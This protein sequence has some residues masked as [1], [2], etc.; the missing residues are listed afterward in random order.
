M[1]HVTFRC[2]TCEIRNDQEVVTQLTQKN[3]SF[4][5]ECDILESASLSQEVGCGANPISPSVWPA[6]LEYLLINA[7]KRLDKCF[8]GFIVQDLSAID[9][10][11][12]ITCEGCV[13][14]SFQSSRFRGRIVAN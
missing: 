3:K 8:G 2:K 13:T 7:M 4:V 1:L 14:E 11:H 5:L 10:D 12:D 6:R 9:D